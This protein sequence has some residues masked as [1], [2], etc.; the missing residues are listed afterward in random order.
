ME[1]LGFLC[2]KKHKINIMEA[3]KKYIEDIKSFT[4]LIDVFFNNGNMNRVI[5]YHN[6]I[7]KI[8]KKI[9]SEFSSIDKTNL[10]SLRTASSHLELTRL[11]IDDYKRLYFEQGTNLAD[12]DDFYESAVVQLNMYEKDFCYELMKRWSIG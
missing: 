11:I 3:V 4:C 6:Y 2:Y 7:L 1:S 8:I 12:F 5:I 9:K 10:D